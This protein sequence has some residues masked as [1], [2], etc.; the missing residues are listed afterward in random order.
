MEQVREC[1]MVMAA[2]VSQCV[3]VSSLP[4]W[5]RKVLRGLTEKCGDKG[6]DTGTGQSTQSLRAQA[7][8]QQLGVL[9]LC[10]QYFSEAKVR[11]RGAAQRVLV[12]LEAGGGDDRPPS[13][14]EGVPPTLS[15]PIQSHPIPSGPVP[16][17]PIPYHPILSR[18][19]LSYPIPSHPAPFHPIPSHPVPSRPIPSH[20]VPSRP[21]PAGDGASGGASGGGA[22]TSAGGDGGN[23]ASGS[24]GY[25]PP[26][27]GDPFH[28]NGRKRAW[29]GKAREGD[30]PRPDTPSGAGTPDPLP[31]LPPTPHPI[32]PTPHSPLP[33]PHSPLPTPHS[34]LH[35]P[36][37]PH[38]P[39]PT[40][41]SWHT[42][43]SMC[44]HAGSSSERT[45]KGRWWGTSGGETM[46]ALPP[47]PPGQTAHT[48]PNPT[49]H[50][51]R[52]TPHSP[53]PTPHSPLPTAQAHL[54]PRRNRLGKP[55]SPTSPPCCR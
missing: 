35:P 53:L 42:G 32:L 55:W 41:H 47:A 5:Q 51:P 18:P 45:G 28:R 26:P 9:E 10:R 46:F 22:S 29:G 25:A 14:S 39:L 4:V 54:T 31:T 36:H 1:H 15:Y 2:C 12:P 7:R 50:A 19:V 3:C 48:P 16:S 40:P 13:P 37:P 49:P 6:D 34:P 8:L 52:P 33:T 11:G 43:P 17:C 27:R 24:H 30:S 38:S 23:G 44:T 20:P 21:A